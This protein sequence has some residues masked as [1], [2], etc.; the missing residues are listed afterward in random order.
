MQPNLSIIIPVYNGGAAFRLAIDSV[1]AYAGPRVQ[2]IVVVDGGGVE[3][4]SAVYARHCGA[5]VICLPQ[6]QG[7]ALARNVGAQVARGE[8][9]F[10]MDADVTLRPDTLGYVI[11]MFQI[12]PELGALIGSY[13]DQPGSPN[14]LSQYKNLLHHYTHQQGRDEASTF[15][16]ACGAIKRSL[17]LSIG[18]FNE[19]YR[20]PSIEDIELGYRLKAAGHQIRLCKHIQVKHLKR[21]DLRSLL[22]A[23]IFY[24]ALPWTE[25]IW[26]DRTFV[27]DL[28][29]DASSRL[30]VVS[31]YGLVSKLV[32]SLMGWGAVWP[33]ALMFGALLLGLNAPV[34]HFF[35]QKRSL[36]FSLRAI[37]WHW[38]Y[39]GYSGY[40]FVVGS[41]RYWLNFSTIPPIPVNNSM[42]VPELHSEF[43]TELTLSS[44]SVPNNR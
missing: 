25:L 12:N 34:Y 38:F 24:R 2:V 10:F 27:S 7:P 41:L 11:Q 42:R 16:G 40:A 32:A 28:N 8:I 17:F 19:A 14:F 44:F 18:G 37:P 29:L 33:L 20:Y 36:W 15:W 23:E 30:S 5:E 1:V 35:H 3:D 21:W 6:N 31:V 4:G 43:S 22:R 39:Y 26:R 9:L 13:D